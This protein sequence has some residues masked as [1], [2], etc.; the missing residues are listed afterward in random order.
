MAEQKPT[1]EYAVPEKRKKLIWRIVNVVVIVLFCVIV[2]ALFVL[3]A[4]LPI[5]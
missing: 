4:V 1:L 5:P 2:A 3:E